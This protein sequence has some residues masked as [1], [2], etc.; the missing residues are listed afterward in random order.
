MFLLRKIIKITR[1]NEMEN[2]I[3]CKIIRGEIPSA[4]VYEVRFDVL[5]DDEILVLVH[6]RRWNFPA[7]DF[8]K[9]TG[10]LPNYYQSRRKRRTDRSAF[11][12][13]FARRRALDGILR[14]DE[15]K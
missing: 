15:G 13:S 6:F 10:R 1:S 11:A 2:C 3:F 14:K 9:L 7:N 4:K 8:A 5:D 12:Y